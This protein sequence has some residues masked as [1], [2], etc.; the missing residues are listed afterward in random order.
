M[1]QQLKKGLK[2]LLPWLA[3]AALFVWMAA[4]RGTVAAADLTYNITNLSRING[5]LLNLWCP[6]I[7]FLTWLC[8]GFA[9]YLIH[10]VETSFPGAGNCSFYNFTG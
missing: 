4:V 8:D 2:V 5:N 6:L 10:D 7:Y 3:L 1:S 9:H